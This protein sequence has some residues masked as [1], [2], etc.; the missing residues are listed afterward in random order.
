MLWHFLPPLFMDTSSILY[1]TSFECPQNLKFHF[2]FALNYL[3]HI[4]QYTYSENF[5]LEMTCLQKMAY[6]AEPQLT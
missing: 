6:L 2:K 5:E 1:V 4:S 3:A